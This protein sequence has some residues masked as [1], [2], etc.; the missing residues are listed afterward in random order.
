MDQEGRHIILVNSIVNSVFGTDKLP[1]VTLG[2]LYTTWLIFEAISKHD[3]KGGFLAALLES[4]I[5]VV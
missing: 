1:D 3:E 2:C 5:K 4:V